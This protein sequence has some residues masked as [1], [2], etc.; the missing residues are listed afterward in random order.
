MLAKTKSPVSL[1]MT[2]AALVPRVSLMSVTVAPAMTPPC[3]SL[4]VPATVPVVICAD[5]TDGLT[6]SMRRLTAK[7]LGIVPPFTA[8][9]LPRLWLLL[10]SGIAS[11]H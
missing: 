10:F 11:V 9:S 7:T 3:E 1:E 8:T 6:S 4:T 5:E 2:G